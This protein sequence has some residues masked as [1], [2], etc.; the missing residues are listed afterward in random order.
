MG[1]GGSPV[2]LGRSPRRKRNRSHAAALALVLLAVPRLSLFAQEA[3]PEVAPESKPQG[4]T[5]IF[6]AVGNELHRYWVDTGYILSSPFRWDGKEWM[7]A[8]ASIATIAAVGLEDQKID[9]AM[10]N[11]RSSQTDSYAKAVTPFG[12]EWAIGI[13]VAT[14]GTG[15]VFKNAELRDTGRDAI[16]A[17]LIAAGLI[18]PAL[19][20]IFGRERPIQGGDGDEYKAFAS[21]DNS[22]PS[23]HSTEA[24]AL[25]SVLSARSQGWV[26][27]VVSY[28]LAS[29]VAFARVNDRAHFASDV[30][31][32]AL[33]GTVVGRTVV[34][35]HMPETGKISWMLVPL[36]TKGATGIAVRFETA[37]P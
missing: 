8:G 15:L 33:I 6:G 31:A 20:K 34:H 9:Q 29:S 12:A 24:F 10:Q 11:R 18:T 4:G 16:E 1:S 35:R 36:Q 14:F 13:T 21:G 27:P 23:G 3:V 2:D 32:G 26:I 25:A 37:G 7:I 5:N 19:K 30:L 28:T 22:F 17:E